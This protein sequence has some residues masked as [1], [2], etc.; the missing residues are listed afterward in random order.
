MRILLRAIPL[1]IFAFLFSAVLPADE[2]KTDKTNKQADKTD[3]TTDKTD[4][5]KPVAK[6]KVKKEKFEYGTK[7]NAK[8]TKLEGS[9]KN[10]T[11][12]VTFTYTDPQRATENQV[13]YARRL[14]EIGRERNP[15]SRQFQLAELQL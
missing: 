14:T 4:S 1:L 10:F 5:D 11:V 12:Q 15:Q 8:L 6:K 3:K 13:F 9:T 2:K 7:F